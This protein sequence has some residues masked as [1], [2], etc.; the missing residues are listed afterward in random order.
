ME[1]KNLVL[2]NDLQWKHTLERK[3]NLERYWKRNTREKRKLSEE[4]VNRNTS[5]SKVVINPNTLYW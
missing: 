3:N 1:A 4:I 5:E 2:K